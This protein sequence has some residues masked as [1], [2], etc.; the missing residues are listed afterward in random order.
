MKNLQKKIK[1]YVIIVSSY[2]PKTHSKAET[3]TGF[4]ENIGNNKLHTLRAGYHNW[5]KKFEAIEKGEA[6]LSVRTWSATP[7]R[8][9][10]IILFNLS[11][12]DGIGIEKLEFQDQDLTKPLIS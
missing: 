9:P 5:K 4:I 2:F 6:I 3:P 12:L 11:H 7:Y 1:T 8:S 10:Q